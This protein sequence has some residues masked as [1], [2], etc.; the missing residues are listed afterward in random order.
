MPIFG[1]R[2][3]LFM[4]TALLAAAGLLVFLLALVW[5]VP[6][7]LQSKHRLS[8]AFIAD[9]AAQAAAHPKHSHLPPS[10]IVFARIIC[11]SQRFGQ[12]ASTT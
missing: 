3:N 7:A 11:P 9:A 10:T 4:N 12:Q 6:V 8:G 2:A 1:P 5:I